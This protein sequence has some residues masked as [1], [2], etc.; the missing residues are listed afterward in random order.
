MSKELNPAAI[1]GAIVVLVL[2]LGTL[3]W[4]LL[5]PAPYVPSPGVG[6]TPGAVVP[7]NPPPPAGQPGATPV[8]PPPGA[9]P[10]DPSSVRGSTR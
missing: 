1:I 4:Y 3:G 5:R 8:A 2:L 10:G 7:G 6:G 9:T